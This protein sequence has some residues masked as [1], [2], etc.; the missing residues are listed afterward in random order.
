M[1]KGTRPSNTMSAKQ[2]FRNP[3]LNGRDLT[4]SFS[5]SLRSSTTL[6]ALSL[7][8]VYWQ[9]Y[10]EVGRFIKSIYHRPLCRAMPNNISQVPSESQSKDRREGSKRNL[11]QRHGGPK[12]PST[13]FKERYLGP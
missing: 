3:L 11:E 7:L 9:N 12:G 1:G 10:G 4:Q 8:D 6:G 5:V 2:A 13:K